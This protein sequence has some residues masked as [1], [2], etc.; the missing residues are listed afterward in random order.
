M[1]VEVKDEHEDIPAALRAH[2][3]D[4]KF[5]E[6]RPRTLETATLLYQIMGPED[7]LMLVKVSFPPKAQ[8]GSLPKAGVPARRED[9]DGRN[10]ASPRDVWRT[11]KVPRNRQAR[12]PTPSRR[13]SGQRQGTAE[14][15]RMAQPITE[16]VRDL[17]LSQIDEADEW[18]QTTFHWEGD[19]EITTITLR[20]NSPRTPE[21]LAAETSRPHNSP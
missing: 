2:F 12:H 21:Q 17:L 13:R 3:A 8:A 7:G 20:K 14:T 19:H 11:S 15:L 18:H 9:D 10:H 1:S 6:R 16:H 4:A 5:D